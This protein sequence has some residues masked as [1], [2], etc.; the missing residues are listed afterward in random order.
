MQ[1]RIG[2][3]ASRLGYNAVKFTTSTYSSSWSKYNLSSVWN[4]YVRGGWNISRGYAE[5]N[6]GGGAFK[7]PHMNICTIGHVDHGKTTLTSAITRYLASQGKAK[8]VPFDDIDKA[9]EEKRRGITINTAHVE[10]ETD[11]RHYAHIDNPGHK[12]FVKNMITGTSLTDAA[13]LVV[14]A[15]SG[16]MPQTR[17]HILLTRQVGV[18]TIIIWINKVELVP[19]KELV[20]MVELELREMLNE[21]QFDGDN[22][23]VVHGSA[24]RAMNL[25]D[26]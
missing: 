6:P 19:D 4:S 3:S 11:K 20:K 17:E 16:P 24:I 23:P 21:Y 12:E 5:G 8:Y 26:E 7:K 22:T 14:D 2:L 18:K 1:R 13:I 10:Y 9:P 15:A 25:T